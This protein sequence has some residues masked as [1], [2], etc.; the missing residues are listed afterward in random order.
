MSPCPQFPDV[1][2]DVIPPECICLNAYPDVMLEYAGIQFDIETEETNLTLCNKCHSF[3]K[4]K[5]TP[6]LSLANH[7]FLGTVPPELKNLTVVEEAMIAMCRGKC[8]IVQLQEEDNDP[9]LEPQKKSSP[10][11]QRGVKGNIIIYPQRPSTIA[12]ILPP[13]IEEITSPICVIFVGSSPPSEEWLR[14]KAVPL[15][16]R[17]EVVR[18]ALIWLQKHNPLYKNIIINHEML[19]S[20]PDQYVLP[21]HIEHILPENHTESLT[22]RYDGV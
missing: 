18:K 14:K 10:I 19:D 2:D 15:T 11:T 17:R 12:K 4:S 22:S 5:R 7:M 13:S 3:L 9:E 1:H 20:L 6:P 8:W 16:V 21:V